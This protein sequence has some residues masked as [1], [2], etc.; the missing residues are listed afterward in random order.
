MTVKRSKLV[1]AQIR[2]ARALLRWSADDLARRAMVGINTVRRAEL[3]ETE[4][5]LTLANEASIRRV[6][7]E[8]GVEF[9]PGN[10]GGP[11]VRLRNR[12]G[13]QSEITNAP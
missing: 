7:E 13:G 6:F 12:Q 4:T 1:G 2:A 11:G 5:S 8:A 9:I 3:S 10:G